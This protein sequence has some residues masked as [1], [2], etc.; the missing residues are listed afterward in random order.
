[1]KYSGLKTIGWMVPTHHHLSLFLHKD[2]VRGEFERICTV[3]YCTYFLRKSQKDLSSSVRRGDEKHVFKQ[4]GKIQKQ[5][6][7]PGPGLSE[8]Y[9]MYG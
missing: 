3:L 5:G 8:K 6:D 7:E 1:V 9:C 4:N 2:F